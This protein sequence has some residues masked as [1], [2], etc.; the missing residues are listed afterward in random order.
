MDWLQQDCDDGYKY[1]EVI[2]FNGNQ[3]N[4]L[5]S[6]LKQIVSSHTSILN[7]KSPIID[8]MTLYML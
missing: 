5:V 3:I 4:Q 2:M 1:S 8:H 7:H 6:T